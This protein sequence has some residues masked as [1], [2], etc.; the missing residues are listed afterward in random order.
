MSQMSTS[1]L[2]EYAAMCGLRIDKIEKGISLRLEAYPLRAPSDDKEALLGYL[3]AFI[4]PIPFKLFQLDTIRVKNQRQNTGYKRRSDNWTIDGPGISFIMG[5][6]A[7]VWASEKGCTETQLL[8]VKDSE[9]MHEIL[10]RLYQSFGFKV[11]REVGDDNAS[12]PDRLVWGAVGTLMAMNIPSFMQE[13]TPKLKKLMKTA[14]LRAGPDSDS[15]DGK[16]V[17]GT[18]SSLVA[19]TRE[20][21]ANDKLLARLAGLECVELPCIAFASGEDA[22]K[23]PS[24]LTEHDIVVITS[25]QAA[26]V[27]LSGCEKAGLGPGDV[28]IASVGAGTSK[29]LEEKGFKPVFE[30]SDSTAETLAKE[31][32][33]QWGTRVLYPSSSLAETKLETGLSERGFTV[34]RLNTYTTIPAPWSREQL[35]T[36]RQADVVT[37]A[38]PS[39]IKVWAERVGTDKVAVVIGPTSAKAAEKAGFSDV[40][41][42]VGSKG[43]AAWADLIKSTVVSISMR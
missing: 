6:M 5:S 35:E 2:D 4:R 25:P 10:I 9:T 16:I 24:A 29:P 43:L 1:E 32:S 41:A 11:L 3:E 15:R 17:S 8:A 22:N 30:P 42:P 13:W 28:T 38:S 40:R 34:T 20:M 33:D 21:G 27:F 36:A 31:L 37:F 23:L 19:L 39:T 26:N 18:G 12:V 7:L 14:A